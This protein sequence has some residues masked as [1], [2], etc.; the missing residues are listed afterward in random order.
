MYYF[1][2]VNGQFE[3]KDE[4]F[5]GVVLKTMTE[6]VGSEYEI[7]EEEDPY[8]IQHVE[9]EFPYFQQGYYMT[10]LMMIQD[11]EW[12]TMNEQFPGAKISEKIKALQPSG[13]DEELEMKTTHE[14]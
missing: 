8:K 13:H 3:E 14:G 5:E 9:G 6:G 1:P 4:M 7:C 11:L 2:E 12:K 10:T